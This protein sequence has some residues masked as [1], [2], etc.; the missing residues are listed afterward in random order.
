MSMVKTVVSRPVTIFIVFALL[1]GLGIFSMVN[2]PIDLYPEIN[3]PMLAIYTSYSGAGP[4]EVERSV[5]RLLEATLS[6]VSG[7]ETVTS[8]SSKG[9]SLVIMSFGYGTDMSDAANSIRDSLDRIRNYL[10]SGA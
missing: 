5:T 7:M 4:E 3:L 8:T 6:S 9:T 2:L 10:P 1:I